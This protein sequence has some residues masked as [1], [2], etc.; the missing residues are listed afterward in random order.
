MR[1]LY[2][3]AEAVGPFPHQESPP[4]SLLSGITFA[5]RGLPDLIRLYRKTCAR[6]NIV[7]LL[8]HAYVVLKSDPV[9][10]SFQAKRLDSTEESPAHGHGDSHSVRS[11]VPHPG[12]LVTQMHSNYE[13]GKVLS[14]PTPPTEPKLYRRRCQLE[15]RVAEERARGAVEV[16]TRSL[17]KAVLGHRIPHSRRRPPRHEPGYRN[18]CALQLWS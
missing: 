14:E 10:D 18:T 13:T 9:Q 5:K 15:G 16:S 2:W 3:V 7:A 12:A 6:L 8:M 17:R 11:Y 1:E 4:T